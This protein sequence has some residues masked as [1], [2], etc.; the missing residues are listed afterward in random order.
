MSIVRRVMRTTLAAAAAF[1]RA[2]DLSQTGRR[3]RTLP[4]SSIGPRDWRTRV[5]MNYARR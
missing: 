1:H 3:C 2:F 4:T 5:V